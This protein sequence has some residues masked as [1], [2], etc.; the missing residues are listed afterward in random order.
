[1]NVIFIHLFSTSRCLNVNIASSMQIIS[2]IW[3]RWTSKHTYSSRV[4]ITA[5]LSPCRSVFLRQIHPNQFVEGERKCSRAGWN[6]SRRWCDKEQGCVHTCTALCMHVNNA[7]L[8]MNY[9]QWTIPR[10]SERSARLPN[11]NAI[12]IICEQNARFS[13]LLPKR[14]LITSSPCNLYSF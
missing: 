6:D 10:V 7:N 14:S 9:R 5:P 8:N 12:Y 1:M 11:V 4:L 2:G 13:P 3:P